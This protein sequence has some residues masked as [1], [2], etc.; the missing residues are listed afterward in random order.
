MIIDIIII[1]LAL[2][3]YVSWVH[4]AYVTWKRHGAI[5]PLLIVILVALQLV[6]GVGLLAL[7]SPA[8]LA[9]WAS[10]S[11]SQKLDKLASMTPLRFFRSGISYTH[12]IGLALLARIAWLEV[13]GNTGP[14]LRWQRWLAGL[15]AVL[16]L[17]I[18][19]TGGEESSISM[20][21]PSPSSH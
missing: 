8:D 18:S 15:V 14:K 12:L 1:G 19:V 3:V 20:E 4:I 10:R 21:P 16:L 5:T 13:N 17:L 6:L 7:F 2:W 9:A 11:A